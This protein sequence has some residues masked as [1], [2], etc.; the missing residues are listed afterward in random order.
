VGG[1][2]MSLLC[3]TRSSVL[4]LWKPSLT[5]MLPLLGTNRVEVARPRNPKFLRA[6]LP[7]T[8]RVRLSVARN[9]SCSARLIRLVHPACGRTPVC[10]MWQDCKVRCRLKHT[11][12]LTIPCVLQ[13]RFAGSDEPPSMPSSPSGSLP[14]VT[15][16]RLPRNCK[17]PCASGLPEFQSSEMVP[18]TEAVPSLSSLSGL[19]WSSGSLWSSRFSWSSL[20]TLPMLFLADSLPWL[21]ALGIEFACNL[22]CLEILTTQLVQIGHYCL[23]D[24]GAVT[25]WITAIP[26]GSSSLLPPVGASPPPPLW[27]EVKIFLE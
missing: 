23:H 1:S 22:S 5:M 20:A 19:L 2:N 26:V 14:R 9:K 13:V 25:N 8:S 16:F 12:A 18:M 10:E 15:N 24:V 3:P 17:V 7:L 11:A 27:H 21:Y 6:Q 4:L